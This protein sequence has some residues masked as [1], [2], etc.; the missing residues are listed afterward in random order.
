MTRPRDPIFSSK[1]DPLAILIERMKE[2]TMLCTSVQHYLQYSTV[3]AT[4]GMV[5]ELV[6]FSWMS[7]WDTALYDQRFAFEQFV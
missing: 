6:F 1:A 2:A 4:V 7:Q 3:F 5:P